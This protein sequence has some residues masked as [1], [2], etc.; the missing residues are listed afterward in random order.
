[1][2]GGNSTGYEKVRID[3]DIYEGNMEELP[4]GYQYVSCHIIFDVNIGENFRHKALILEGGH[5][6]TTP[7]FLTYLSVVSRDIVKISS[8]IAELDYLKVIECNIHN[9]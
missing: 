9:A 4:P 6:T 3:F 7:S 1:M 2:V 8:T 5:K